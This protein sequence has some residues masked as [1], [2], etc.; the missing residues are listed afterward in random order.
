[1][2]SREFAL[3]LIKKMGTPTSILEGAPTQ[4]DQPYQIK[5]AAKATSA[6]T[7]DEQNRGV[8]YAIENQWI[9]ATGKLSYK[10]TA[11]GMAVIAAEKEI[12][13]IASAPKPV[14]F[15]DTELIQTALGD[16]FPQGNF[17][18]KSLVKYCIMSLEDVQERCKLAL[19]SSATE[20][21]ENLAKSLLDEN[22]TLAQETK[23]LANQT[24][25]LAKKTGDMAIATF[26]VAF[27]TAIP[28]MD[29]IAEWIKKY[30][31]SSS[32]VRVGER[33][34][35]SESEQSGA[36]TEQKLQKSAAP[37]KPD[38]AN[39][40]LKST[41]QLKAGTQSAKN[42]NLKNSSHKVSVR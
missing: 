12:S 2:Q 8:A 31:D 7:G 40:D 21:D 33:Q 14:N 9:T 29:K 16:S 19:E 36:V 3:S 35:V 15:S 38:S 22:R 27:L 34:P 25:Q 5:S 6:I 17:T 30:Q 26:I 39:L 42:A 20:S 11:F 41:M 10:I 23:T 24:T 1:M 18:K 13:N 37:E 28:A 32:V 4:P